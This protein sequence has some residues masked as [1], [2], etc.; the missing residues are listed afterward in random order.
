[1]FNSQKTELRI[2]IHDASERS[3]KLHFR[4]RLSAASTLIYEV[5][6][7]RSRISSTISSDESIEN[8]EPPTKRR[9]SDCHVIL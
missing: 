7:P 8:N 1:M 3:V 9:I 5:K 2:S 6:Q 4:Q